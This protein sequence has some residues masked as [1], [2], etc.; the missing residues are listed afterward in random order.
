MIEL[1][2]DKTADGAIRQIK[3]KRYA[4]SLKGYGKEVILVGVNYDKQIK[5]HSCVIETVVIS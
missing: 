3:E 1:K 2:W 5:K 4:G